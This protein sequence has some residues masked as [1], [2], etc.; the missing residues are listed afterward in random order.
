MTV[1]A[2]APK[3]QRT[4]VS[5]PPD[6]I[7]GPTLIQEDAQAWGILCCSTL[8]Q[9]LACPVAWQKSVIG[10]L[11][12]SFPG[13]T[14]GGLR[15][16]LLGPGVAVLAL[17]PLLLAGQGRSEALAADGDAAICRQALVRGT[18]KFF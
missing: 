16:R 12:A 10:S 15:A 4:N 18:Q 5:E 11:V 2:T 14:S 17:V 8:T 7:G 13:P 1:P 6:T 3:G 9:A